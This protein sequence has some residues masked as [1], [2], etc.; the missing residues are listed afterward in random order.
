MDIVK[1]WEDVTQDFNT[2]EKCGLCWEFSAPFFEDK[3]NTVQPEAPC[4]IQLMLTNFKYLSQLS[5]AGTGFVNQNVKD[6]SFDLYVLKQTGSEGLGTNNYNEIKGHSKSDSKWA[7]VY[8]PLFDCLN[9]SEALKLCEML[10]FNAEITK[11]EM[12]IVSNYQDDNFDG[13]IIRA[14]IRTRNE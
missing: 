6:Y 8:K 4:C 3:L 7:K 14:N 1:F 10:G 13:W 11:W 5:Y 2:N 9:E 12:S